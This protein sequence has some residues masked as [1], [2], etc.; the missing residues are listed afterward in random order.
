MFVSDISA[1]NGKSI[2]A[3]YLAS[4]EDSYERELGRRRSHFDFGTEHPTTIDWELWNR[5]FN[6]S[7]SGT[8][9]LGIPMPWRLGS[10]VALNMESVL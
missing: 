10:G 9:C 8:M 5:A 4:W 3:I 7:N 6:T 2:E 1:A